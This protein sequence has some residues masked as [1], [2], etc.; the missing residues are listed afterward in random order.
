[1]DNL[2]TDVVAERIA[3]RLQRYGYRMLVADDVKKV[4]SGQHLENVEVEEAIQNEIRELGFG[5]ELKHSARLICTCPRSI[6]QFGHS[7]SCPLYTE[8]A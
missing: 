1:M 4:A 3:N 6:V 8:G 5:G 2:I 7:I